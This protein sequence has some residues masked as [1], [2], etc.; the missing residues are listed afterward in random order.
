MEVNRDEAERCIEIAIGALEDAQPEKARRFLEKA[1]RLFPTRRAQE[2][3][4]WSQSSAAGAADGTEARQR[5]S[6]VSSNGA[7]PVDSSKPYTPEQAE[8]VRR[9]KQCK[10][11]YEILGVQK[12]ASEDD[13]KKAYRKLA[14][15]FHPDKNHA[16]GAT[17][18]FKAIGN[19][20]AVLSN[21][22]K[23]RQY[24]QLGS[25]R[26]SQTNDTHF[27]ADISPE[28]LFNMFFGGGFPSSNVHMYSNGRM[29]FNQNHGEGGEHRGGGQ[30]GLALLMQL[31]PILILVIVSALSQMMV[32][33]P[34]YSLSFRPS[35]GHTHKRV[36]E[37]LGVTYYVNE[38]FSQDFSSASLKRVESSVEDDYISNLRNNCW[39]EKQQKE[40]LL[41]RARYFGDSDLY[42]RAQRMGTPSCS[43]LSEVQASLH[44]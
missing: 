42:Q 23:R 26:S 43:R 6:G 13:L 35:A 4:A 38:R 3:L 14:L 2:L 29:R 36:T 30:G 24:D 5:R 12:D 40:G 37:N 25:G 7:A 44:G 32:T 11:Y 16:P 21:V 31:M 1:Q 18:A 28:D 15:K 8:A 33:N 19:A 10:N 22:E 39:K 27:Q 34:P 17:E 41:Y 20:Y 9:I